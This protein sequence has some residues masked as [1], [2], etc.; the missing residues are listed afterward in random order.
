M[1]L[2]GHIHIHDGKQDISDFKDRLKK[3]GVDGGALFS[4]SPE[5]FSKVDKNHTPKE[6]LCNLLY[7]SDSNPD[8]YPVFWIDPLE[9][10]AFD[11][12]E[13]AAKQGVRAFKVI[14]NRFYPYDERPMEVFRKIAETGKPIFFHSGILWDGHN[15]S[16]F[17]RPGNF[18]S[19]LEINGLKFSLA[20]IS[21]PWYDECIAVYGKFLNAY[22]ENPDISVEM[23]IDLTPGTP[24][25]YRNDALTKI[26]TIGYDVENNVFFGS[27]CSAND[28]NYKWTSEWVDRDN[29]IYD[30]IALKDETR[31][32]VYGETLKRFL[33]I[34]KTKVEK[35]S[36]K[37]AE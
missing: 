28:Y 2:D 23:F 22:S 31:K 20:H 8:F 33:G 16:K 4:I 27:D 19:L 30:S 17:N 6:R 13:D 14:C 35:K 25:I 5:S 36:L 10:T 32:K 24:V 9:K 18:E 12:V 15:S 7:W 37:T 1:F 21:W 3:A 29:K 11:Q 34:T 26:F